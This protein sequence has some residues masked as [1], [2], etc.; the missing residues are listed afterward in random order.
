MRGGRHFRSGRYALGKARLAAEL[1]DDHRVALARRLADG[2]ASA[3]GSMPVVVVTNADDVRTWAGSARSGRHRRSRITRR[4]GPRGLRPSP[5]RRLHACRRRAR[6]PALGPHPGSARA[7]GALPIIALVP[8]H[9]DDGTPV[10]AVPTD[11]PFGF[12]YGPGSFRRHVAEARRLGF[13]LRVVRDRALAFD[14]DSPSTSSCSRPVIGSP[15]A[16]SRQYLG[17]HRRSTSRH[18]GIARGDIAPTQHQ[19]RVR[20]HAH[21]VD[22]R[23]DRR[24]LPRR[25]RPGRRHLGPDDRHHG[26]RRT[27]PARATGRRRRARR[28]RGALRGS[29]GRRARERRPGTGGRLRGDPAGPSGRAA[30]TRPVE[31]VPA[32]PGSP[33]CRAARRRRKQVAAR[34]PFFF[35][36]QGLDPHRPERLLLFEADTADHVED[37]TATL[38]TKLLALLCHRSQWRVDRWTSMRMPPTPTPSATSSRR[39]SVSRPTARRSAPSPAFGSPKFQARQAALTELRQVPDSGR[40]ED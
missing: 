19:V 7:T 25:H 16:L 21:E 36:E 26:P 37:V 2:V 38:P 34:D 30:R 40:T 23:R 31:A 28:E 6:R 35:P 33:S 39:L 22:G 9:R 17:P 24:Q 4:R 8:C 29:R 13:G 12:A 3:A 32:A 14:V 18:L 1:D 10:L 20:G 11:A 15:F 5:L 27:A